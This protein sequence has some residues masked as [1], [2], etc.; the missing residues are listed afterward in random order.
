MKQGC[1]HSFMLVQGNR[2][3]TFGC[4]RNKIRLNLLFY[5]FLDDMITPVDSRGDSF[6]LEMRLMFFNRSYTSNLCNSR[7]I[8]LFLLFGMP[9]SLTKYLLMAFHLTYQSR[10]TLIF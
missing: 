5:T 8:G 4:L 10:S 6:M 2:F 9:F 1:L 3:R 7:Y